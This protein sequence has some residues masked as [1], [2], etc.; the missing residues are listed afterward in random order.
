MAAAT[1]TGRYVWRL[2]LITPAPMI[3]VNQPRLRFC[4]HSR[5]SANEQLLW[6]DTSHKRT[7]NRGPSLIQTLH[8]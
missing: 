7:L 3:I 8:V 6:T 1:K 2:C 4:L 5:T